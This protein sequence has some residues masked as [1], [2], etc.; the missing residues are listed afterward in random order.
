MEN[1]S[2]RVVAGVFLAVCAGLSEEGKKL[3]AELLWGLSQ[4]S[5]LSREEQLALARIASAADPIEDDERPALRV[6]SG[7]GAA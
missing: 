6:I 1:V 2:T 3:A 5:K 7:G 4:S